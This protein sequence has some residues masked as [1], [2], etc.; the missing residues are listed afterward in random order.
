MVRDRDVHEPDLASEARPPR[1]LWVLAL[2]GRILGCAAL[3]GTLSLLSRETM[4]AHPPVP[5]PM[6]GSGLGIAFVPSAPPPA[7]PAAPIPVSGRLRLDT[8]DAEPVRVEPAGGPN[9]DTISRGDFPSIEAAHLRLTLTR[10]A[11]AATP[12]LF[13]TLVRRAA[14]G[15]LS[16]VRT[17]ARGRIATKFGAMETLEA[18]LAGPPRRVCTGFSSVEALPIR[19]DGWLC[20]PLG[21]PPEPRT[22]ACTLDGLSLDDRTDQAMQ[23][24]FAQ[25]ERRRDPTCASARTIS[26]SDPAGRT[27][28]IGRRRLSARHPAGGEM[29]P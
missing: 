10:A 18:T 20:A 1:R 4:R 12:S 27:G 21:Q 8:G 6:P 2:A 26:A 29:R 9:A 24:V 28:S 14:E 11:A 22:L 16:V 5:A 17:G 13:V 7:R 15:S 23:A 3:I 19:L 25:A